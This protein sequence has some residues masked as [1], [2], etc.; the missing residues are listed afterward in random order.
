MILIINGQSMMKLFVIIDYHWLPISIDNRWQSITIDV[1][2]SIDIDNRWTID[3]ENV[4]DYSLSSIINNYQSM[5]ID[6][7]TY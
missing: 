1:N 6:Q 5:G 2:W 4:C 3:D 7:L